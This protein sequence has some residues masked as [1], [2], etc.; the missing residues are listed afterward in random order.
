MA[1]AHAAYCVLQALNALVQGGLAANTSLLRWDLEHKGLTAGCAASVAR[2]LQQHPR[3]Q[4]LSLSRNAELG[5]A[6]AAGGAITA[7]TCAHRACAV[8]Q[9]QLC[10]LPPPGLQQLCSCPWAA[11][12]RLELAHSGV[13]HRVRAEALAP[14]AAVP[15]HAASL[16]HCVPTAPLLADAACD[17]TQGL[18]ALAAAPSLQQL[19]R[20][21]LAHNA[22]GAGAAAALQQ[23]LQRARGLQVLQLAGTQLGDAG[24]APTAWSCM[25]FFPAAAHAVTSAACP[26]VQRIARGV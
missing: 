23:L 26:G 2:V 20:L 3:L 11:L 8:A 4:Q 9:Q 13:T 12:A 15:A 6:G 7:C 24:V 25:H 10:R 19:E 17:V 5:D 21:E 16:L 1:A 14:A 18:E 22:L